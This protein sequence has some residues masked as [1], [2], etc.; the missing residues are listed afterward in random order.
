MDPLF[1]KMEKMLGRAAA[2]RQYRDRNAFMGMASPGTA[3]MTEINRGTGAYWLHSQGRFKD[4][5][6][7]GGIATP[8]R[9]ARFPSDMRAIE[10]HSYHPTGHALPM[11]K[12]IANGRI[13]SD[14]PKVP[15]Y[16]AA[17]GVPET[18]FQTHVPV[19]DAHFARYR[20]G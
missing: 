20:T 1:Q 6:D 13:V 18:G 4:F 17:S 11:Q 15:P 14:R 7:F 9:G 10:G 5:E 19:P 2:I 3:P 16:V 12:Y 8:D